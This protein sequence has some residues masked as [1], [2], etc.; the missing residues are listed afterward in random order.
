M[1]YMDDAFTTR[2]GGDPYQSFLLFIRDILPTAADIQKAGNW[3]VAKRRSETLGGRDVEG[4]GFAPY[5]AAYARRAGSAVSL[6]SRNP[7]GEHM[8]DALKSQVVGEGQTTSLEVGIFGNAQ[9]ATRARIQN[10]GGTIRTQL[11]YGN[12]GFKTPLGIGRRQTKGKT[13]AKIPA[14]HWLGATDQDLKHMQ[15]IIIESAEA[16][17]KENAG[18]V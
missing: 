15:D 13:F 2:N 12:G 7:R 4:S 6:Y 18:N 3:L 8:L 5:S 16:R 9:L 10:E 1:K 11:G 14:R 17:Q